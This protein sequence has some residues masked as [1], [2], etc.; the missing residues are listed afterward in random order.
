LIAA[1][2]AINLISRFARWHAVAAADRH[3]FDRIRRPF[4][5]LLFG[6][7]VFFLLVSQGFHT[8]QGGHE[9]ADFQAAAGEMAGSSLERQERSTTLADGSTLLYY[10]VAGGY[11][12]PSAPLARGIRGYGGEIPLAVWIDDQGV[13]KNFRLLRSNET[14]VYLV[15]L[16]DWLEKLKERE[17]F[18]AKPFQG[19]DAVTGATMSSNAI[20]RTLNRSTSIFGE[21][22]LGRPAPANTTSPPASEPAWQTATLFLWTMVIVFARYRPDRWR[23]RLLLMVSLALFGIGLNLQYASQQAM[24]LLSGNFVWEIASS[25]FFL[26]AII[27]LVA[28]LFGNVYCGYLCPFGAL[29]ELLGDLRPTRL[30]PDPRRRIWRYGRFAKYV[31][32]FFFVLLFSLTRD[33]SVLHAD[34]LIT[35]FGAAR[36]RTVTVLA[37]CLLFL[38]C[39]FRRFWCRNLCPAGAFLALLG[40]VRLLHRFLPKTRPERCDLGVRNHRELDCLQCDRCRHEKN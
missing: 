3:W 17:M 27:P 30:L 37:L 21:V 18:V 26:V 33:F 11:I 8:S 16:R 13:L 25:G 40:G 19:V 15:F 6:A 5:Y 38:S 7:G 2:I 35:I 29:Q 28:V 32:L 24:A 10:Q 14:P 1:V 22:A 36:D 23:R 9:M 31:L 4:G 20:L 39:F 12:F 34:P